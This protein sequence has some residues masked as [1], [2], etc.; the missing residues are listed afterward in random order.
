MNSW[1][2]LVLWGFFSHPSLNTSRSLSRNTKTELCL[3]LLIVN[4]AGSE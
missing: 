3:P 2:G 4:K 1:F